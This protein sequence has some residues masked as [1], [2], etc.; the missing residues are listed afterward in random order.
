MS[1]LD[2]LYAGELR[3]VLAGSD[4]MLGTVGDMSGAVVL[5]GSFNPLHRGHLRLLDV[6]SRISGRH[7]VFEISIA[8][9]DKPELAR[10][11]LERRLEQFRGVADVAVTRAA[12]FSDKASLLRGAWFVLGYDTAA[13][14][15]DDRYYPP[16]GGGDG[17]AARHLGELRLAGV[18]FMVA[19]RVAADGVFKGL[20]SL[21]IPLGLTDMFIEV[22]EADFREDVSSTALRRQGRD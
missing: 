18:R 10:E 20:S 3:A 14:L 4:G 1:E 19:G 16:D 8:N 9:V 17:S 21:D 13:R 11:E 15:V 2:R 6:A 5:A 12:L 22:P 7:G